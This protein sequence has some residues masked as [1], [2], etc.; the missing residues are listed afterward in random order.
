MSKSE[1]M[2][3][4]AKQEN[5]LRQN[6]GVRGVPRAKIIRKSVQK[7]LRKL[8]RAETSLA[9]IMD[10]G[11]EEV[12][13]EEKH[14]PFF[15]FGRAMRHTILQEVSLPP[16]AKHF[17]PSP[18]ETEWK[19]NRPASYHLGKLKDPENP[20]SDRIAAWESWDAQPDEFIRSPVLRESWKIVERDSSHTLGDDMM[21]RC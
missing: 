10:C 14:G 12:Q 5:D 7:E 8:K 2:L 15:S 21:F 9:G 19:R 3:A 18:Q 6:L 1:K 4:I 17:M 13:E 11:T 16:I 20:L